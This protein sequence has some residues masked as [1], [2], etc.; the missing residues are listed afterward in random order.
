MKP[1]RLLLSYKR[2]TAAVIRFSAYEKN[3]INSMIFLCFFGFS[4]SSHRCASQTT[5]NEIGR[6]T[7]SGTV[8]SSEKTTAP[9]FLAWSWPDTKDGSRLA[10]HLP[11]GGDQ[12]AYCPKGPVTVANA[13]ITFFLNIFFYHFYC[14]FW[15]PK[16][17]PIIGWPP[18][19]FIG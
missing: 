1:N 12:A 9:V 19:C 10:F 18:W 3:C 16:F 8:T 6:D 11:L 7:G 5:I 14:R 2:L 15:F 13:M 4:Q 17:L